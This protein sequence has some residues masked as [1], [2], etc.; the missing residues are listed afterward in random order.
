MA[1]F[2]GVLYVSTFRVSY[3]N[4]E[5]NEAFR[6]KTVNTHL[7]ME[8]AEWAFRFPKLRVS[9]SFFPHAFS[10]PIALSGQFLGLV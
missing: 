4:E 7:N 3:R 6:E 2:L 1:E 9:L 8:L 5:K 10:H